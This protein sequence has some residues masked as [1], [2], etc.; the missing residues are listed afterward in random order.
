MVSHCFCIETAFS[1][2][3][4][5]FQTYPFVG[6]LGVNIGTL[7]LRVVEHKNSGNIKY[8]PWRSYIFFHDFGNI[9]N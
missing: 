3:K 8:I 4:P 5:N 7:T 2:Y 1:G 9:S 6:K